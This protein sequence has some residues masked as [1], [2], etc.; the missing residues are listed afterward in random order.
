MQAPCPAT[1]PLI[2]TPSSEIAPPAQ[3][4]APAHVVEVGISWL[5]LNGGCEAGHCGA[6]LPQAVPHDTGIVVGIRGARVQRKS[7]IV[8]CQ[9]SAVLAQLLG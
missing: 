6:V 5:Q 9:C 1:S 7:C 2:H 8:V 4:P 3:L